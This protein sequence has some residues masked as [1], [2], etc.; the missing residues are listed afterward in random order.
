M[1]LR[2]LAGLLKRL[3]LFGEHTEIE[4]SPLNNEEAIIVR[5]NSQ[6]ILA[7]LFDIKANKI[8][9]IYFVRNPDK[10]ERLE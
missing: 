2:F 3:P 9:K 6:I 5:V 7:A 1:V 4:N 8:N 10:L